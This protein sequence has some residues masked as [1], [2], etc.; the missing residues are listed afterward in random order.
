[1][2]KESILFLVVDSL[3]YDHLGCY[4]YE[5]ETSPFI[6]KMAEEGIKIDKAFT[7]SH[8]TFPSHASIFSGKLPSKHGSH[9][10]EE[11]YFISNN[12]LV[13][14]LEDCGYATYGVSNN[15]NLCKY[16]G[17]DKGFDHF[18]YQS[19]RRKT[20]K[21]NKEKIKSIS[22][23][24]DRRERWIS[25]LKNAAK[26]PSLIPD[27]LAYKFQRR[28]ERL[29]L[30]DSGDS[31][32]LEKIKRKFKEKE[33]PIFYF[34]NLMQVHEPYIPPIGYKRKFSSKKIPES[35]V[36][37][38]NVSNDDIDG[39]MLEERIKL[40]DDCIRYLDGKIESL[41]GSVLKENPNTTI[42]VTSD[43][44]ELF[45][46]NEGGI[47]DLKQGHHPATSEKLARIPFIIYNSNTK[48]EKGILSL[49]QI[50]QLL[51]SIAEGE[52]FSP[53]D[54]A[55]YESMKDKEILRAVFKQNSEA[56]FT[57]E[58][59]IKGDKGLLPILRRETVC[60]NKILLNEL[61]KLDF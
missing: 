51:E 59:L 32:A 27:L 5:R 11:K 60:S 6:D 12:N 9:E 26:D 29:G 38:T 22:D 3:R 7:T 20:T 46:D 31:A 4:G 44:G 19:V 21:E 37:D 41:V 36:K 34:A 55:I 47:E 52:N 16:Y 58:K 53:G 15:P 35:G 10:N 42:I 14:K 17:F 54:Y 23:T 56:H 48:V 25:A 40:Y 45:K 43:H 49:R 1:M 39:E 30:V 24:D 28:T 8:W 13:E 50:P 18:E 33:D 61:N 2:A 57:N